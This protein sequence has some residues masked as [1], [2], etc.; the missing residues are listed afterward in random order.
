MQAALSSLVASIAPPRP[1]FSGSGSA[2]LPH[3]LR[4]R[5]RRGG[6]RPQLCAVEG[7]V[8]GK[9]AAAGAADVDPA[10]ED[11]GGGEDP[12]PGVVVPELCAGHRIDAADFSVMAPEDHLA[13]GGRERPRSGRRKISAVP[14]G[15]DAPSCRTAFGC[16]CSLLEPRSS[17]QVSS[18]DDY[19]LAEALGSRSATAGGC[20][21]AQLNASEPRCR[22][23]NLP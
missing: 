12:L 14:I 16:C 2:P 3:H 21:V 15:F 1:L 9:E 8:K 5:C 4:R 17:E 19:A 13:V 20:R 11:A 10:V 22:A 6:G 18:R 23:M 7:L